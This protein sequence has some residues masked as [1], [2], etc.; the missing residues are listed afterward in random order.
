LHEHAPY[1]L[2]LF[3][4]IGRV[5]IRNRQADDLAAALHLAASS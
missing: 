3:Q 4:T 5:R 2:N 1:E